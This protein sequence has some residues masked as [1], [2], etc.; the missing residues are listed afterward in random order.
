MIVNKKFDE[1]F[2]YTIAQYRS[3]LK[4]YL[5]NPSILHP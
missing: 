4:S 5:K 3:V 2:D 1:I